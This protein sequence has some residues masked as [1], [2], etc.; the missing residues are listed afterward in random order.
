VFLHYC[1]ENELPNFHV[2]SKATGAGFDSTK[3][4]LPRD[5]MQARR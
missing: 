4:I 2:F 1:G 5:A 3:R